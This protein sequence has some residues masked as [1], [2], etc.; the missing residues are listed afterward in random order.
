MRVAPY[1]TCCALLLGAC[2]VGEPDDEE[3]ALEVPASQTV[4]AYAVTTDPQVVF[5]NFAGPVVKNC[6]AC[7]NAAS[8]ES[9]VV[10]YLGSQASIDFAPFTNAAEKTTIVAD[11]RE[12]FAPYNIVFTTT[13]PAQPPYQMLIVSPTYL[14]HHGIAPLDCGNR[15][16]DDIAFV[17]R[18]GDTGFYPNGHKI[19]Q[20]AAH[21]LGHSFGLAHVTGTSQVMQWASSGRTFSASDYD[22]THPS[23]KCFTGTVQHA[24]AMLTTSLGLK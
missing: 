16:R 22:T 1:V 12:L 9:Y 4:T 13:R 6:A 10:G 14:P 8:N 15:N 19:A 20:A 5:V 17:Y 3:D 24:A 11:L 21:E 18:T 2:E 7:S 23:G